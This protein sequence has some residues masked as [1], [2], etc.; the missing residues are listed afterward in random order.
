MLVDEKF[1]WKYHILVK[2]PALPTKI[3]I[4][5]RNFTLSPQIGSEIRFLNFHYYVPEIVGF[6][7][8]L[9]LYLLGTGYHLVGV[10]GRGFYFLFKST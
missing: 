10:L 9:I 4:F 5:L 2:L 8:W 7:N 3:F 1:D 6:Q